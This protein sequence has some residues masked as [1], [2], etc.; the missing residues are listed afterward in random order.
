[1]KKTLFFILL[2]TINGI[3]FS[4]VP[5]TFFADRNAF[6]TYPALK[7]SHLKSKSTAKKMPAIENIQQLLAEDKE[8]ASYGD[9]PFRFG[10]GF[11]VDYSL[12]DG[13]WEETEKERIWSLNVSSEGA[14]SLNFVFSELELKTNATVYIFNPD[15]RM[16]YGPITEHQNIPQ[17]CKF[18]LTD[19]IAGD[20]VVIQLHE[21]KTTKDT[22]K[23]SI[24]KVIHGYVN[25]FPTEATT[26]TAKYD[27]HNDVAC[28]PEWETEANSVALILLSSGNYW[29][30]GALINNTQQDKRPFFL[31]A[32]HCIDTD[33]DH[34]N[35]SEDEI[36]NAQNW[37]FRFHYKKTTCNGNTVYNY[38]TYNYA[39]FRAAWQPT[40]FLLM[41][42]KN[43]NNAAEN[44]IVFA[45][46]DRSANISPSGT[47]IHHPA[48]DLMKISFDYNNLTSNSSPVYWSDNIVSPINTHWNVSYDNGTTEGGSSGSPLF[49][50]NHR[51]IGQLHGGGS[52]CPPVTKRYGRFDKSWTGGGTNESRL[53]NWLDPINSKVTYL[54]GIDPHCTLTTVQNKTFSNNTTINGCNIDVKNVTVKKGAKLTL[55]AEKETTINGP[56]N[57]EIGAEFE[58]K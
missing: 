46:W 45:G 53:S 19:L 32:F 12:S 51:I 5:S 41:E 6:D 3:I 9:F 17:D 22:S 50:Q 47:G 10:Y 28:Y 27:C 23:L 39:Y 1:M 43:L 58:I 11:D 54:D 57:V 2:W 35:L 14:Y 40:D 8:L 37:A 31:S 16:V 42:L 25:M 13:T 26:K 49:N 18:F 20:N 7:Q 48:G 30:S 38:I 24:S 33:S 4:Q 52:G 55:D 21:P 15:G 34:D 36:N 29:C 56:F 44:N